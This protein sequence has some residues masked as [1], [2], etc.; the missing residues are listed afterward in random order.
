MV[1][2]LVG[3]RVRLPEIDIK[4]RPIRADGWAVRDRMGC[5]IWIPFLLGP[6]QDNP[7]F[8][9]K[10]PETVSRTRFG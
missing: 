8:R 1:V 3:E 6:L 4:L 2:V 7:E 5:W 9:N 10:D